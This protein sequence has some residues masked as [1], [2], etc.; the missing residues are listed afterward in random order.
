M[1]DE[2]AVSSN[3]LQLG[4]LKLHIRKNFSLGGWSSTGSIPGYPSRHGISLLGGF[5]GLAR[6]SFG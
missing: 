6:Q 2:K 4:R 1:P 5:Q 3:K